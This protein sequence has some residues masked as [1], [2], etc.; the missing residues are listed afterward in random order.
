MNITNE[1]EQFALEISFAHLPY[2]GHPLPMQPGVQVLV[3]DGS[4]A[5]HVLPL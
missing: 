1:V 5:L 2:D 4:A 3:F